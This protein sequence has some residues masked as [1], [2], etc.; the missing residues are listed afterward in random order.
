MLGTGFEPDIPDGAAANVQE[1]RGLI[2]R[3]FEDIF[4]RLGQMGQQAEVCL[5]LSCS[6]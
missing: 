6:W 3:V 2:P 4:V 1:L 5:F